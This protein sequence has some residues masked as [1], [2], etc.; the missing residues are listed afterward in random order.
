MVYAPLQYFQCYY[1][2]WGTI[3]LAVVMLGLMFFSLLVVILLPQ[4]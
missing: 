3:D 4:Y 1:F 2:M